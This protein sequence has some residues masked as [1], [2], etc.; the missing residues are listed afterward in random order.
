MIDGEIQDDAAISR[1]F[2]ARR[3]PMDWV[4]PYAVQADSFSFGHYREG[5]LIDNLI[6]RPLHKRVVAPGDWTYRGE[7]IDRDNRIP[8]A[9]DSWFLWSFFNILPEVNTEDL[10]ELMYSDDVHPALV[11]LRP[12]L[13]RYPGLLPIKCVQCPEEVFQGT[14]GWIYDLKT[15]Y[16]SNASYHLKQM[17]LE[18]WSFN[19][20]ML[21]YSPGPAWLYEEGKEQLPEDAISTLYAGYLAF[22]VGPLGVQECISIVS[23][24]M[25]QESKECKWITHDD[26]ESATLGHCQE[27]KEGKSFMPPEPNEL[28]GIIGKPLTEYSYVT[29]DRHLEYPASRF[30]Y[31][32]L[33]Y[34][35]A[36]ARYYLEAD[37]KF[38]M[39]GELVCLVCKTMPFVIWWFQDTNPFLYSG[40]WF[41]TEFYSSGIVLEVC[42]P[43]PANYPGEEVTPPYNVY[44]VLC[45]GEEI[46]LKPTDFLEYE[47]G[48]RV[49]VLKAVAWEGNFHWDRIR[50]W[51]HAAL[52]DDMTPHQKSLDYWFIAPITF[53]KEEDN[54]PTES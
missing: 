39:P 49:A 5:V 54:E 45:K 11:A 21:F 13:K 23:E 1:R 41:E 6:S 52:P 14:S 37:A 40:N 48:E 25:D 8:V 50:F 22:P 38:P 16:V 26:V 33:A 18:T 17:R 30:L 36:W 20:S 10:E 34:P 31:H 44:K 24:T 47:V 19:R 12:I 28:N 15:Q 7:F 35:H 2:A 32:E 27:I 4:N 51:N 9:S 53:Y 43:D 42:E 29:I 46:Y 3:A